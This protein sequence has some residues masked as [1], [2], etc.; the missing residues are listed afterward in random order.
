MER[1]QVEK[2]KKKEKKIMKVSTPG[3][4]AAAPR[5][6]SSSDEESSEEIKKPT[7]KMPCK[8]SS[9]SVQE[10]KAALQEKSRKHKLSPEQDGARHTRNKL[11]SSSIVGLGHN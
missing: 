3:S 6:D 5:D 9:A 1:I 4:S 2:N 11:S 10:I 7:K 8:D